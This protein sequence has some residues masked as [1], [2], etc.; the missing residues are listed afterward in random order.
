MILCF[1]KIIDIGLAR[2]E[3]VEMTPYVITRWYR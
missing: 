2:S 3:N 1:L